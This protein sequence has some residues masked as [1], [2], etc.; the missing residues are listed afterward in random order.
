MTSIRT[1]TILGSIVILGL[2]FY[3]LEEVLIPFVVAWVLAYLLVPVVDLLSRRMLREVSILIVFVLLVVILGGLVLGV[4]PIMRDEINIFLGQLPTY[5]GH[6]N[7]LTS[8][9]LAHFHVNASSRHLSSQIEE[10]LFN[11]G[12]RLVGGPSALVHT[13]TQLV[14]VSVF[15]ALVPVVAFYLLRDWHDLAGG[16]ESFLRAPGR[17]HVDRFL[18]VSDRV[19]RH[20][21]HGELLVMLGIGVMYAVGYMATGIS[22]GLVLGLL[23]GVVSVIP[24]ASFV[25]A[26]VPALLISV[27]QFHDIAHPSMVV[28]TIAI[29]ELVGNTILV[30]LLVGRYVRVHPAAVLLLMFAGG[31]L[32]GVM[33]MVLALPLAAVIK[34]YL[35]HTDVALETLERPVPETGQRRG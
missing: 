9:L 26:G 32:F 13:A 15:I 24:F 7:K 16:I 33:G 2:A 8:G 23:A 34:A 22:L 12:T 11:I 28:V 1:F 31:A 18:R 14:K 4:V 19:L 35:D 3:L 17:R 27:A 20:F 25:L 6:I 5:T 29:A 21:I 10:A 30:P